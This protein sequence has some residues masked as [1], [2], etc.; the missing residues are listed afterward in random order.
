MQRRQW[1]LLA[2]LLLP[3]LGRSASPDV[4]SGVDRIVAIGDV[5]GDYTRFVKILKAT[6]LVDERLRWS[7]GKTHLVQT[8]DVTDRGPDSRKAMDLLMK[9]E[10]EAQRAGGRVHALIGNHEAMNVY[11]D[12]RYVSEEEYAAFRTKESERLR[13]RYYEHHVEEAKSAGKEPEPRAAWEQKNPLGFIE[14][15]LAF[16]SSGD[17]GRW[18]RNLNAIVQI[19]DTVFLHGGISPKFAGETIRSLNDRIRAELKDFSKLEKGVTTDQ[20]GPLWY[21]GWADGQENEMAESLVKVLGAL[22]VRRM[23]IG[24]TI[25]PTRAVMSRFGGR[26]IMIDVGL[27][28]VYNGRIGYLVYEDK[29]WQAFD[30]Q[31]RLPIPALAD[32]P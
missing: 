6:G 17:Y 14:H 24:H 21:R 28:A 8:G 30:E 12:L 31:T 16:N 9:L 1:F 2:C 29:K 25:T 5:H 13:N 18:I 26:V 23:V 7:G 11:G 19:N 10:R 32:A 15:R 20:E 22:S 4:W 3:C 27:S